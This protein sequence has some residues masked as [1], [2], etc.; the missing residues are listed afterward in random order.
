MIKL[1]KHIIRQQYWDFTQ[2]LTKEGKFRQTESQNQST[3]LSFR[4]VG[5][6]IPALQTKEK[7]IPVGTFAGGT[8]NPVAGALISQLL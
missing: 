2:C 1:P 3:L 8:H 7:I 4:P 5:T 6:G